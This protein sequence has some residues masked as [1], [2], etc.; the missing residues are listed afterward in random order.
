MAKNSE[1]EYQGL[2]KKGDYEDN[3]L[4]CALDCLIEASE[5]MQDKQLM[6]LVKQYAKKKEKQVKSVQDIR[7]LANAMNG[8]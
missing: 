7:D 3:D 2:A 1:N 6:K 8:D 4:D 5:I